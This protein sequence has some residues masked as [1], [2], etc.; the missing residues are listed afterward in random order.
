[1]DILRRV[2][3]PNAKKTSLVKSFEKRRKASLPRMK[4]KQRKWMAKKKKLMKQRKRDVCSQKTHQLI[5]APCRRQIP[6]L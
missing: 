4:M 6:I 5:P 1:M 2:N 3:D